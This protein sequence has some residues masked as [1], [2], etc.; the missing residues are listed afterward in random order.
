[1]ISPLGFVQDLAYWRSGP[2]RAR[3]PWR[4]R[5]G[6]STLRRSSWGRASRPW[7]V[8]S[9]PAFRMLPSSW[10]HLRSGHCHPNRSTRSS[11][12]Q[13]FTGSIHPCESPSRRTL[14]GPAE[15]SPRS[16]RTT[17]MAAT[18]SSSSRSRTVISAGFRGPLATLPQGREFPP[19]GCRRRR[20]FRGILPSSNNRGD[21]SRPPFVDTSGSRPIQR[22]SMSTCYSRIRITERSRRRGGS[23]SSTALLGSSLSDTAGGSGSATS[24]NYGSLDVGEGPPLDSTQPRGPNLEVGHP[25]VDVGITG[26][27]YIN[28]GRKH[29]IPDSPL[30]FVLRFGLEKR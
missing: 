10:R 11:Q 20:T 1:M 28:A 15:C 26:L 14:F 24:T 3:R 13:R 23:T 4:W 30:A 9:W 19:T 21:L 12:P 2:V 25:V 6:I 8:E 22:S 17:S 5:S 27:A 16:P 7:R 29:D 18:Q